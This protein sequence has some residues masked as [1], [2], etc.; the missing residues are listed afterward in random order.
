MINCPCGLSDN[1]GL[2]SRRWAIGPVVMTKD[3]NHMRAGGRRPGL[4]TLA[5]AVPKLTDRALRRRGFVEAAIVHRWSSIVGAE[6]AG[7]CVPDRIAFPRDRQAGAT[8]HLQAQGARALELQH[9]EPVL[10][11]RINTVFG[12][13]ALSKIAIRQG[14]MPGDADSKRPPTRPLD[15]EEAS[16]IAGQVTELK[17]PDLKE[18]LRALGEAVLS[19]N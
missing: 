14:S 16:W 18:A 19:R 17:R 2:K 6:V 12:Y 11:E 15:R 1:P 8:L 5:G 3:E 9:L 7:W 13:A 10:L 4:R